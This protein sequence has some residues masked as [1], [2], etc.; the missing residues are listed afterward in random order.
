[1]TKLLHLFPRRRPS[2]LS[3][4]TLPAG[5]LLIGLSLAG[6][7]LE[8]P[9]AVALRTT[10][11]PLSGPCPE[12]AAA[13]EMAGEVSGL[14]I[15]ITG[16][17]I[18]EAIVAEGG[19]NEI[20]VEGIPA[21]EGRQ[22]SVF[23]QNADGAPT[24]RGVRQNV[25]I[26]EN[27][28]T[29]V[30][31]LLARI[32]DLTCARTPLAERR[33]FHSAT[34]L[35]DG[36][37]LLVGGARSETDA[38]TTCGQ[39]C[40]LLDATGTAELYDPATGTFAAAGTLQVPRM[41]HQATLLANGK[42]AISGGTS[43]AVVVPTDAANPF[44]IKPRLAPISLIELWDPAT[45]EFSTLASDDPNGP[46][47][48]HAATTTSD[49]FLFLSGGVPSTNAVND[50]S[51]A[52]GDTTLC[53]P[54]SLTCVAGP[55]LQRRRAGHAAFL[56][57]TG[58]VLVWGGSVEPESGGF[59][60][61]ILRKGSSAFELV[62][63]A[64]FNDNRF[65]LFFAA[66]TQYQS[67]R[68]LAA[69]GLV[70]SQGGTFTLSSV[71]KA[72]AVR[73]AVYVFDAAQGPAGALSAGPYVP[74]GSGGDV[75]D[76][77]ALREPAFLGSAAALPG[78]ARAVIAGGFRSL[79]LTPSD[80]LDLY[81]ED[82]FAVS[83]LSVGGQPRSLR[84]PRGGLVAVGV[85]DGTVLFSGGSSADAAGARTPRLTAEIFADPTNPRSTP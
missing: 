48:F 33:S 64:G 68:V 65:N 85:G 46:R 50:L 71:E 81:G 40:T 84:E 57:D 39:G 42:V 38:S 12:Q 29:S 35:D 69:G 14:M 37:V 66:T 52:I 15:E 45:G 7:A 31:V 34:L 58:D 77:L 62:D 27:A 83:P 2:L 53:D 61:E 1:M 23:G 80:H 74:D 5:T 56:L 28:N 70:R 78:G 41:F 10:L 19:V 76:P 73:G 8:P 18:S 21:G 3:S 11:L 30:D 32:A 24:W 13:S 54:D 49:G 82:P 51:N 72:G 59:R 75:L 79:D 47:L 16:P 22:V 17:G 20:T 25:A 63:T 9:P 67:Y 36:R 26:T 6:C 55:T 43:E 44:P 60:P 4:N